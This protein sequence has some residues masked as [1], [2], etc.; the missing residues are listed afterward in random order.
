MP[1]AFSRK[2]GARS[3][4]CAWFSRILRAPRTTASLQNTQNPAPLFLNKEKE[5]EADEEKES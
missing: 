3:S 2:T 5:D 4:V 1:R